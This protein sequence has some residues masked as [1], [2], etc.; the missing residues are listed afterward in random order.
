MMIQEL[1]ALLPKIKCRGLCSDS[2][3]PI[4]MSEAEWHHMGAPDIPHE[5]LSNGR[6]M[7]P[8]A[9]TEREIVVALAFGEIEDCAL[10]KNGR[11]TVY[12][13]R[14]LICRLWGLTPAM[15]CPHGCI[16]ERWVSDKDARMLLTLA[17]SIQP[18]EEATR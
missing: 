4:G 16:P 13:R 17:E 5:R 10:L 7:L 2:C 1:Y 8:M 12:D 15:R 3:G 9:R 11:C 14:P 18:K 6:I